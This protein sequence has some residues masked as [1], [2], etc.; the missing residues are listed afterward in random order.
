MSVRFPEHAK[1]SEQ[2]ADSQEG[3]ATIQI[4]RQNNTLTF[5]FDMEHPKQ[6]KTP[7]KTTITNIVQTTHARTRELVAR[8]RLWCH[9]S[10]CPDCVRYRVLAALMLLRQAKICQL[11]NLLSIF[12]GVQENLQ[13]KHQR[14]RWWWNTPRER[15]SE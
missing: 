8:E 9:E 3:R 2:A 6:D 5:I 13:R 1:S 11:H 10:R 7:T 15:A 12:H 14:G 4:R